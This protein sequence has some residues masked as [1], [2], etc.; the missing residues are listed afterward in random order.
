VGTITD[1]NNI[2]TSF[3]YDA[4]N[5]LLTSTTQ[6]LT[7]QYGYDGRGDLSF[8]IPP[9]G[10]R[11]DYTYSL[12][13][14]LLEITDNL[15]NH[16]AYTYD[17]EG[18]RTSENIYDPS[19]TLKK[20]LSFTYDQY[21]RLKRIVNPDNTYTEYTYDDKGNRTAVRNPRGSSTLLAYDPLDRLAGI[22]Q[23]LN[24]LTDYGYDSHDNPTAVV[25]PND[26][27]THYAFDDF[28][29]QVP[30]RLPRHGDHDIRVR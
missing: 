30:G 27:T 19:N 23:P 1:P 7:T 4:R 16:I 21:N 6:S 9:E 13:D 26:L 17:V 15:G 10:T 22:T 18:N 29:G 25:D 2:S 11:I 8:V 5:R 14:K 20:S 24:T 12:S 28:G 3:T